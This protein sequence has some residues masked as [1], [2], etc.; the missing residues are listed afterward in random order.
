MHD[1]V[2][3]PRTCPAGTFPSFYYSKHPETD[4]GTYG[5][6]L[7]HPTFGVA[8]PCQPG[9]NCSY[10]VEVQY[11]AAWIRMHDH[12]ATTGWNTTI[13]HNGG[14]WVEP[15]QSGMVHTT[16][17][18][19]EEPC[20]K[21]QANPHPPGDIGCPDPMMD[22]FPGEGWWTADALN[23]DW[24]SRDSGPCAFSYEPN[25]VVDLSSWDY[26]ERVHWNFEG[27]S[28]CH[29]HV[30]DIVFLVCNPDPVATTLT[31]DPDVATNALPTDADH[32]FT[33]TV[34]DQYL[35][36]MEGVVVSFSTDF[37][38]FENGSQYAEV[39]T[40]VNGEAS[41]TVSSTDSGT[42]NIRAWVD[43]DGNDAYAAGEVTDT[44]STK[45]WEDP[46]LSLDPDNA[47]NTLPDDPGHTFT[48]TVL[49][50]DGNP[51]GGVVVSFSTDFGEFENGLQ[52]TEDT[53]NASGKAS[54]TVTSIFV[55]TANIRAWIDRDG[56]NAYAV[57]EATDTP[58]TKEWDGVG[59]SEIDVSHILN[60][61]MERTYDWDV[62]KSVSPTILDLDRGESGTVVYTIE[63]TKSVDGNIH[64]LDGL[65]R[66]TNVGENPAY[67]SKVEYVVEYWD[68]SSVSWKCLTDGTL[69]SSEVMIPVDSSRS[70]NWSYSSS[71]GMVRSFVYVTLDNYV[72][73][74]HTFVNNGGAYFANVPDSEVDDCVNVTD[75]P[76]VP[77]GFSVSSNYPVGGWY[78]CDTVTFS[79]NATVTND[80][81]SAG[82][83]YLDNT[84]VATGEDTGDT[85]GD[86]A[87]VTL[88]VPLQPTPTPFWTVD[89][90]LDA[91][92]YM[93]IHFDPA[94]DPEPNQWDYYPDEVAPYPYQMGHGFAFGVEVTDPPQM[95]FHQNGTDC[96]DPDSF[97]WVKWRI[98]RVLG[99]N[100]SGPGSEVMLRTRCVPYARAH[101]YQSRNW[102]EVEYAHILAHMF[103]HEGFRCDR[104]LC[105]FLEDLPGVY[106]FEGT[107]VLEA[108]WE[109]VGPSPYTKSYEIAV[110]GMIDY[111]PPA[112]LPD[113]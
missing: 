109:S 38:E 34:L 14:Q 97:E 22:P 100:Y 99:P 60:G 64:E 24:D 48:A 16:G 37:G 107:V 30:Y 40:D 7:A 50:Q 12:E 87:R 32:T 72:G 49:D 103:G 63:A 84:A 89:D 94:S 71:R 17:F 13:R 39:A 61:T 2:D 96:H 73:G 28:G 92:S 18:W 51:M 3:F 79:F 20:S 102:S 85:D 83:H 98:D 90:A 1:T 6:N 5:Y 70:W 113:N 81:A 11:E 29:V 105:V 9:Y 8:V 66:V 58:S 4:A 33:A 46:N 26:V 106:T 93:H 67:V 91:V 108:R 82:T 35:R 15:T 110:S 68:F 104:D 88:T 62:S 80:S 59:P 75:V 44:P 69:L 95:C 25:E 31:L 27:C 19:C 65:V 54:A 55:G 111:L 10:P 23:L 45:E 77:T 21:N 53:T 74:E 43:A 76:A 101:S 42:A 112:N 52:Y 47:T 86:D 78:T 41:V 36:P 56:N 57:G